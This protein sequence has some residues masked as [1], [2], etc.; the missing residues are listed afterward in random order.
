[1]FYTGTAKQ[2]NKIALS[3]KF[4]RVTRKVWTGLYDRII[5]PSA[6]IVMHYPTAWPGHEGKILMR[7][8]QKVDFV[9]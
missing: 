7:Q 9:E 2:K 5:K 4:P 6:L 8:W 1:M 3:Y